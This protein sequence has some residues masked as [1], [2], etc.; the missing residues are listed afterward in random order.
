ML[1][2]FLKADFD[3]VLD[4]CPMEEMLFTSKAIGK[5]INHDWS[6]GDG[7][8][9]NDESPKHMYAQTPSESLYQVKY[10]ITDNLGCQQSITKPVKIYSSCTIY[11]PNAFTPNNDGR[12]DFFGV[13]NAVK[14]ANFQ[15][16]IYNRWGQLVFHSNNWK[17]TWNGTV[18]GKVQGS[19]TFVWFVKYT[20]SR[21]N[22][23]VERKG[24]V[25][26]IK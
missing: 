10:T 21:N 1:D 16:R 25:V 24:T 2:N 8:N 17:E 5:V 15:L 23:A 19:G 14:A 20:D 9:S 4:N 13:F 18:Q 26:L 7:R 12:N 6:F 22:Q 11:I 3:A